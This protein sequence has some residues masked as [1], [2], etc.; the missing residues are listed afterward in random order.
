MYLRGILTLN[1]YMI[2][3]N[4]SNLRIVFFFSHII[5]SFERAS[6]LSRC[7]HSLTICE[8]QCCRHCRPGYSWQSALV[9]FVEEMRAV[10]DRNEYVAAIVLHLSTDFDCLTIYSDPVKPQSLQCVESS[11][12]N[13]SYGC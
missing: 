7:R 1:L 11:P 5:K 10:L 3:P 2:P 13:L 9:A 12:L 8:I 4:V 6:I